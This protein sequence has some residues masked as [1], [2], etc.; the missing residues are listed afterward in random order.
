[1]DTIQQYTNGL[2]IDMR[3]ARDLLAET[4]TKGAISFV[5]RKLGLG[6]NRAALIVDNLVAAGVLTEPDENGVRRIHQ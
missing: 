3:R 2:A 6:Y 1:M 4:T 5:Q